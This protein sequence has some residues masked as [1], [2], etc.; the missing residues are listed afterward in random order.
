LHRLGDLGRGKK[1]QTNQER[2]LINRVKQARCDVVAI[3]ELF[4]GSRAEAERNLEHF[5][6]KLSDSS[7]RTFRGVTGSSNDPC[8]RNGFLFAVDAVSMINKWDL[9]SAK[10]P[11]LSP[12]D[13]RGFFSRGPVAALF[14]VIAKRRLAVGAPRRLFLFSFH[15]KSKSD[16]WKDKTKTQ[17]EGLRMLQAEG[18]RNEALRLRDSVAEHAVV[19]LLGD[20][21]SEET[22]A[23]SELL[24]GA[25][26]LTDFTQGGSCTL[27][28]SLRAACG[29]RPL[30]ERK[31]LG[32]FEEKQR[33]SG[34]LSS[35]QRQGSYFYRKSEQLIDEILVEEDYHR[36]FENQSG[37]PRA[38]FT[39]EFFHGSDHKLLWAAYGEDVG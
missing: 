10:L 32:L 21:N 16:G 11:R 19:I 6:A 8:I 31:F 23:A 26:L 17:Y 2:Y 30:R 37:V 38:G 15:L 24:S 9:A 28:P 12:A 3:Q 18:L 39:G 29:K 22:G 35:R 33:R 5:A 4:G 14:E 36:F 20:R 13:R 34:L 27:G 7:G 25:L 1:Q